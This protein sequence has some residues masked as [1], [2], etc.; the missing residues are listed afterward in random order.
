MDF[1]I[2]FNNLDGFIDEKYLINKKK[3]TRKGKFTLKNIIHFILIQKGRSN[4][5]EAY[6]FCMNF[7]NNICESVAASAIG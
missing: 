1:S 6:E 7:K 4:V 3:F 5:I 2:F